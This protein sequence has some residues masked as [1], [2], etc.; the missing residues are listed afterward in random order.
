MTLLSQGVNPNQLAQRLPE[1][2]VGCLL[3]YSGLVH[4][5]NPYLFTNIIAAY[6]VLPLALLSVVP[7]VLPYLMIVLGVCLIGQQFATAARLTAS[8]LFVAFATIQIRAWLIGANI[9]CGC[10]GYANEAISPKSIAVPVIGAVL[11]VFLLLGH[12][13]PEGSHQVSLRPSSE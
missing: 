4:A 3:L 10:F 12:D 8:I 13:L 7:F 2:G 5:A 6:E 9:A 11:C 1:I